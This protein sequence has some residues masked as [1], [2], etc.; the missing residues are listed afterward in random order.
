[1]MI[2]RTVPTEC[3]TARHLVA[4]FNSAAG[5]KIIIKK[6]Y[7]TVIAS[8]GSAGRTKTDQSIR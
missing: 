8:G 4:C 5:H 3:G 7:R 2:D 6:A 1:M